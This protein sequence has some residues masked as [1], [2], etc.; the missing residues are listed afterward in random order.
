MEVQSALIGAFVTIAI[1][2]GMLL[3][4]RR[5]KSDVLFSV[6]CVTLGV[7]FLATFFRGNFGVDPWLRVEI[8]VASIVPSALVRL[9]ADMMPWN[10][11]QARRLLNATYP[12]SALFALLALSPLGNIPALQVAAAIYIGSTTILAGQVMMRAP[13][14]LRLTVDFARRR[15]LAIGASLTV[16]LAIAGEVPGV[17]PALTAAGH[18]AVMLYVFFLA[19]IILRDRLLDLNEFIGRMLI[20]GI[21]AVLFA[22]ISATLI[23]LGSN[24]VGRLFNAVVGVIILLTLYE[25]LKD[26][27]ETKVIELFFRERNRLGSV[28]EDLALRMQHG[29]L[30]PTQMATTVVD[31]LHT[32]RR[33][34]HAA[35]YLLESS[36]EGFVC[37]A[38]EG[39][40]PSSR[41]NA[42]EL[43]ALWQSIQKNRA[44]LLADQ[45]AEE[46][47]STD[48]PINRD[49]IDAMRAASGDLVF[50][51]V[52]GE[53]V[54]GFLALR[55]DR[56]VEP[57]AT[58]EI[59]QLM[60]IADVAAT[61]IWNSQLAEKLR[62]RE[63][64]AA[65]GAMA[66]GLAHEIRNPLG[67][68]KGA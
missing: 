63:R 51:F 66:A 11:P 57:Y 25:P 26:R 58:K 18:L 59:A 47:A 24:D 4:R 44:P 68:I 35:V 8:A 61:V 16:L 32:A 2:T 17:S 5:R 29:V 14:V 38:H 49:L 50:P 9:F 37:H 52:S 10:E 55:D 54:L 15:Y 23:G 13:D 39:P 45:L 43:P 48:E 1:M 12:F 31:T 28:L 6:V 3:R 30:D 60:K 22:T 36:G 7:W 40:K 65:V 19:Q 41:V 62:E 21:L 34:T 56:S 46:D 27:L 67:A 64:L 53:E 20:L 42:Y 33:A